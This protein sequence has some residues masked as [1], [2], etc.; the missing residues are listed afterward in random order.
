M[1]RRFLD[2]LRLVLGGLDIVTLNI[3]WYLIR[4][5]PSV[6]FSQ[7]N[8][9][10]ENISPLVILNISWFLVAWLAGVYGQKRI[11]GFESFSRSSMR[12]FAAWCVV[13]LVI[14]YVAFPTI[15]LMNQVFMTMV[16]YGFMLLINRFIYLVFYQYFRRQEK[17]LKKILILGYNDVS[18]KLVSYFESDGMNTE[19]VGF[20]EDS[21]EV[22]ELSNYPILSS[23]N[24]ALETSKLHK[25]NEIYSTVSP[26]MEPE[27]YKIMQGADQECIRFKLV[28]DL[29]FFIKGNIHIDYYKDIPVL[30]LRTEPLDEISNRIK[31]RIFDVLVSSIV[32]LLILSWLI[33]LLGLIIFLESKGPIFFL[34]LRSGKDN[35]P[36]KCIKFRSMVDNLNANEVQATKND[37]RLTRIGLFLRK[38]N[39]DEFP[40]FLNVLL[41][42]MS[43][44]GPRPHMLKHTSD[45][46][47]LLGKYMVRQ[48]LKPG[49]TG[50]AQVN[51]LR[52]ETKTLFQM[53]QRVEHDIWYMENWSVW[54]DVRIIFLTIYS[55]LKGD[56]NAF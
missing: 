17:L 40:Q 38:S 15:T 46:S 20:C 12:A 47:K 44:V 39:L 5:L 49:I 10:T 23:I 37:S 52:G 14:L 50:W 27:I 35:K 29:N 55:T 48:F 45:Y 56:E 30:S 19:I 24:K 9:G 3:I 51:G 22:T 16:V 2:L 18:K 33:P 36:F 25:V 6:E 21:L 42:N 13:N 11:S 53:Q 26:E 7:E 32:T 1:Q 43:I 4:L 8:P 31:K 28:P 41:G 34:Q 54:L